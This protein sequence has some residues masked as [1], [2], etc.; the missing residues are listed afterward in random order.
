MQKN[1]KHQQVV[2]LICVLQNGREV[3]SD[4]FALVDSN[5]PVLSVKFQWELVV[6]ELRSYMV[7]GCAHQQCHL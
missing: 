3:S 2:R 4:Y 1:P 5:T 6:C 7:P